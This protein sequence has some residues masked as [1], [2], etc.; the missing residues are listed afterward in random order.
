[1]NEIFKQFKDLRNKIF[2]Y[3][4]CDHYDEGIEFYLDCEWEYDGNTVVWTQNDDEYSSEVRS[5][6]YGEEYTLFLVR[7]DFG[8]NAMYIFKNKNQINE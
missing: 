2:E 6:F 5:I 8:S 1:M 4:Y 3:F 7:G